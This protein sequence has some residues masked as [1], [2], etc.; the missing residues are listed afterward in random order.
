MYGV[1]DDALGGFVDESRRNPAKTDFSSL[2]T[3]T[4]YATW[5]V[6][7]FFC[8]IG[9]ILCYSQDKLLCTSLGAEAQGHVKMWN[10]NAHAVPSLCLYCILYTVVSGIS[11]NVH[12]LPGTEWS[13]NGRAAL[14]T[15]PSVLAAANL[16]KNVEA[17]GLAVHVPALG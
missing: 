11:G 4:G 15:Q 5:S 13:A 9:S 14:A 12:V 6:R 10:S 16:I 1:K 3:Y 8:Y 17:A 7:I 2:Q